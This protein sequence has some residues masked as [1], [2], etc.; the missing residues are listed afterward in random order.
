MKVA[1]GA[2]GLS[3]SLEPLPLSRDASLDFVFDLLSRLQPYGGSRSWFVG[4][5]IH[6]NSLEGVR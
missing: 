6:E 3:P 5:D 1:D 4:S 2:G